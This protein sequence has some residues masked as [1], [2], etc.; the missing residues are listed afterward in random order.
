MA[1]PKEK[2][3]TALKHLGIKGTVRVIQYEF[4]LYKV[5]LNGKYFGIYDID[6]DTF[7]D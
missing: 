1:E 3:I 2:I 7:V 6:R 5:E 4:R